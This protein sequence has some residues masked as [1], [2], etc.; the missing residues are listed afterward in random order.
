MEC[1]VRISLNFTKCTIIVDNFKKN[2]RKR[3]PSTHTAQ[4]MK[5]YVPQKQHKHSLLLIRMRLN[6]I[7]VSTGKYYFV[8]NLLK[9]ALSVFVDTEVIITDDLNSFVVSFLVGCSAVIL[10]PER[11]KIS[12][13]EMCNQLT[14]YILLSLFLTII[15]LLP[16]CHYS[17]TSSFA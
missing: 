6:G 5:M 10:R 12:S 14:G 15:H 2:N 9:W 17:H 1:S 11:R 8:M 13:F 4:D 3:I 7:V 16:R